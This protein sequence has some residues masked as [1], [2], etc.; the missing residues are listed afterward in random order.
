MNIN[1]ILSCMDHSGIGSA[2]CFFFI[3]GAVVILT[4]ITHVNLMQMFWCRI[5]VKLHVWPKKLMSHNFQYH[6]YWYHDLQT[7]T[8]VCGA[9]QVE[10]Q[11]IG[12]W[13]GSVRYDALVTWMLFSVASNKCDSLWA[14]EMR[15]DSFIEQKWRGVSGPPP[16]VA[17]K[18]PLTVMS[19][20]VCVN[21]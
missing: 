15:Y 13:I 1:A 3:L 14:K 8:Y 4:H 2:T 11:E 6:C 10:Q 20:Q 19:S 21:F 12:G 16:S 7:R 5:K 9:C 18:L 17:E